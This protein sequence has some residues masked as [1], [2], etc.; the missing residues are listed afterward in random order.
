[1]PANERGVVGIFIVDW[2][3]KLIRRTQ[4]HEKNI[5]FIHAVIGEAVSA[6]ADTALIRSRK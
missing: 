6:E 1:M 2:M 3:R 4:V 5:G